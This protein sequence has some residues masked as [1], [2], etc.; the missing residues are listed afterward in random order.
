MTKQAILFDCDGTLVDTEELGARVD[1]EIFSRYGIH[2]D[3]PQVYLREFLG[4]AKVDIVNTINARGGPVIP[5]DESQRQYQTMCLE[6]IPDEMN[7]FGDSVRLV[8]SFAARGIKM[9]VCSNGQ[10]KVVL[11]ELEVA[12]YGAVIP[13]SHV[14]CV[15]DVKNPKPEPD[16]YLAGAKHLGVEPAQC[17]VVED[18]VAGVRA[19]LAAGMRVVG[20]TGFAHDKNESYNALEKAGCHRIINSL[21]GLDAELHG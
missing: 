4:R 14:F 11:S 5:F 2:Y 21:S 3:S 6:R 19:G 8:Q 1:I 10:R 20:Y 17:V 18:S 16:L 9:A 13:S 15:E 12:G 7:F